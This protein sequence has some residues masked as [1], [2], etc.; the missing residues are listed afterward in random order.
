MMIRQLL[1]VLLAILLTGCSSPDRK[2]L[3]QADSIIREHP[4]SAM[5]IL[6]GIDRHRLHGDDL[7]FYALLYTQAQVESGIP[8]SSDSLMSIAYEKYGDKR[9]DKGIRSNFYLGEVYYQEGE[10]GAGGLK[11]LLKG[12]KE[13]NW[14]GAKPLRYYLKAY[15]EAK[16]LDNDYWHARA[17]KRIRLHFCW[18]GDYYEGERYA[19]EEIVYFKKAGRERDHRLAIIDHAALYETQRNFD[20]ERVVLDS[21]R[22]VLLKEEP[23]DSVLLGRIDYEFRHMEDAME[24][25][26]KKGYKFLSDEEMEDFID[27]DMEGLFDKLEG[28]GG[29]IWPSKYD[30]DLKTEI[31]ETRRDYYA[32]ITQQNAANA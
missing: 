32:E 23:I 25:L 29:A 7:A 3:N 6:K 20:L 10:Q 8:V 11:I 30:R 17:A 19:R 27:H 16:R 5:T 24:K 15:D 26:K 28:Y 1:P 18:V 4:D 12:F 31:T 2:L 22:A 21:L 9:G 14:G 13:S